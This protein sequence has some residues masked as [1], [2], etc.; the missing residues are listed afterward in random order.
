MWENLGYSDKLT[1]NQAKMY[2]ARSVLHEILS[3]KIVKITK[4]KR[5][6]YEKLKTGARHP[7]NCQMWENHKLRYSDF[8]LGFFSPIWPF[9][10]LSGT[11]FEFSIFIPLIFSYFY[12][13][14][15]QDLMNNWTCNM[16]FGLN[17]TKWVYLNIF[18][19]WWP[20]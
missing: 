1:L 16:Y 4:N 3:D 2:V 14:I 8:L 13:F 6:E 19:L 17:Q 20:Y 10:L 9:I 18:D 7:I 15:W 11:C 12:H 5:Y